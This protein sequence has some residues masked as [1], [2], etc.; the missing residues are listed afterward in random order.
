MNNKIEL[1]RIFPVACHTDNIGPG[2]IFVAVKGM[3]ENGV[4]YLPK[5]LERGART[6]VVPQ[7]AQIDQHILGQIHGKSRSTP[8]VDTRHALAELSALMLGKPASELKIIAITGT[9]GKTTTAFL[10]E[11]LLKNTGYK[12]ALLS[13]VENRIFLKNFPADLIVRITPTIFMLFS[14]FACAQVLN[15]W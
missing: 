7:D 12:V 1:P 5:A 13:S 4:A 9:K 8:S 6:F 10:L 14:I 2:S 3:K 15:G 11:H